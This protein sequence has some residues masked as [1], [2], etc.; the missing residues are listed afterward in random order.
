MARGSVVQIV[1]AAIRNDDLLW[2]SLRHALADEGTDMTLC[3][4]IARRAVQA[5]EAE[6]YKLVKPVWPTEQ[7][8]RARGHR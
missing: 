3:T 7:N 4:V 6:G 1:A 5:L 8:T 2:A